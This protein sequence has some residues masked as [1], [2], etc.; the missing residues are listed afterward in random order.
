MRQEIAN[1][2]ERAVAKHG[3]QKQLPDS[4]WCCIAAEE[5]GEIAE[6]VLKEGFEGAGPAHTDEEIVQLIAVLIQWLEIRRG[7]KA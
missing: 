6:G 3:E 1:E 4:V 2:I 5:M 7:R